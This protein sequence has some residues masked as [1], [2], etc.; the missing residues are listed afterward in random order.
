M[1]G[2]SPDVSI[3]GGLIVQYLVLAS[4]YDGTL[5]TDG[6]VDAA[7]IAALE[8]VRGSGRRLLLV[9]GRELD[10]LHRIF[11]GLGL[12]DRVVAENGAVLYDPATK[13]TRLLGEPPPPQ[14]VQM[15]REQGVQPL[16]AGKVIVATF[17]PHQ[18]TVLDAIRDLGLEHQV[19]FNKDAVMVLPPGVNKATGLKAAL[20]EW[21]LSPDNTVG[22]GDAEN[23]HAFLSLC[24]CA[25]A[26]ANALPM[27]KEHADIVMRGARGAGVVELID[28]LLATD[29]VGRATRQS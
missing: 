29:L 22:V 3:P 6:R 9:T 1:T 24:G 19:I 25:V 27:L 4:D 10:D 28:E 5:A 26:V 23:D 14:L 2:W 16:S 11:P 12:F 21:G 15:L 8:R 17:T 18:N 13:Q 20:D 7:T